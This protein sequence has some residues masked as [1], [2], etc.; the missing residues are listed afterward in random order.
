MQVLHEVIGAVLRSYFGI[1]FG[2]LFSRI[3]NNP[4]PQY[5]TIMY[6]M[7]ASLV[8]NDWGDDRIG[9]S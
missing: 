4:V 2:H 8:P 6:H 9:S 1:Y 7:D 5:L 3:G